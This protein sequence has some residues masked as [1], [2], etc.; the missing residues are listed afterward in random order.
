MSTE[1][2]GFDCQSLCEPL[3]EYI[4]YFKQ[5]HEKNTVD[6]FEFLTKKSGV[7]VAQNKTTV[8][9]LQNE[10]AKKA[11]TEK[12]IGKQKL[13]RGI[14]IFFL[15]AAIIAVVAGIAGAVQNYE[16]SHLILIIGGACIIGLNIFLLTKIKPI[17][18]ALKE[19]LTAEEKRIEE[20]T[21]L[22]W[23]Q[24]RELNALLIP[25]L[26]NQL[27]MKTLPMFKL[28]KYFDRK[29]YEY[30]VQKFGFNDDNDI[31]RSTL[32]VQSG[33]IEGNPF[34]IC[35]DLKHEMGVKTYTGSIT[36]HWTTTHY[37]NGKMV[38]RHHSE[39]LT[40]SVTKPCPYYSVIS[41]LIYANEA[42]PDLIFSRLDSDAENMSQ[43]Q[44]D[45]AVKKGMKKLS[46][47]A[48]KSVK[49]GGSY[50]TLGNEE[51]EVLFGATDRNHEVQFRLL[52]TPLAQK[53]LLK[54]MKEKQY[55]YGDDFAFFKHKMINKVFPQHIQNFPLD[56]SDNYFHHYDYEAIKS[57]F[58]SYNLDYMRQLYFAFAPL[59][60]IPLY[61]QHKPHEY[62]YEGMYD[63]YASYY[64]HEYVANSFGEEYFMHPSS[65]TRNILKTHVLKS[66][67]NSDTV[68][69]TAYG[70]H[71]EPRIDYINKM[72]GDGN[73]HT[74]PV[75][76]DEYIPVAETHVLDIDVFD[77]EQELVNSKQYNN[78][79]N[80]VGN[81]AAN[82]VLRRIGVY[83][84]RLK[85]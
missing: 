17:L 85:K 80:A 2:T 77:D 25:D 55:G 66:E 33:E 34:F 46:K 72:G 69:V 45:R 71:I 84:A 19:K 61:R 36:I 63:S 60:A 1:Q 11:Q 58:I 6:M 49:Q 20:L 54:L 32:F 10:K 23:N 39:V 83:L 22:A 5:L 59:M 52:F 3:D 70:Y 81:Q 18:Q 40:A 28:D 14:A 31:N 44:I 35:R 48:E 37:E 64:S 21:T 68:S 38:T 82:A 9:E 42:A 30:L 8:A 62:I 15:V 73:I 41:Y 4:S 65:R 67:N 75:H 43:K 27:F 24:M 53:N 51:F 29:R 76:W 13:F 56:I 16:S 78:Y 57:K 79:L 7:D 47:K 12:R 50:T 74:I 26:R